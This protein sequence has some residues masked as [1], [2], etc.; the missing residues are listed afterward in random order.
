MFNKNRYKINDV[1]ININ[2]IKNTIKDENKCTLYTI[3]LKYEF[4]PDLIAYDL[5]KD[6]TMQDYLAIVNDI[7]NSPEGF[8][9]NRV[10]KVLRPEYKDTV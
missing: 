8:Y 4:R 2:A 7:K 6:V 9:R 10:L 3:P 1:F 5:Y